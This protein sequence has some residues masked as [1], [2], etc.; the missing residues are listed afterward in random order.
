MHDLYA[1]ATKS[2]A[3]LVS[4]SQLRGSLTSSA[5]PH[6]TP[7]AVAYWL[8]RLA[9]VPARL[10][11]QEPAKAL[12]GTV[13]TESRAT[14][15]PSAASWLLSDTTDATPSPPAAVV[16]SRLVAMAAT[17]S[18]HPSQAVGLSKWPGEWDPTGLEAS[19]IPFSTHRD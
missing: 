9:N 4:G 15:S 8:K 12:Q 11:E 14:R 5:T 17:P 7:K 3:L 16:L 6:D 2:G 1:Y 13:Q 18:A 10:G 19:G